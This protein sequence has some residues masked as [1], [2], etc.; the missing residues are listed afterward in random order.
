MADRITRYWP[1]YIGSKKVAE[2]HEQTA[3]VNP[4]KALFYDAEGVG[5]LSIGAAHS[6]IQVMGIDPVGG[7]SIDFIALALGSGFIDVG[8]PQ[9]DGT[10]KTIKMGVTNLQKKT[11]SETGRSD[12]SFTLLGGA[13]KTT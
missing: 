1:L 12:F 3:D 11:N 4:N 7:T 5:G 10:L 9:T 8:W 13:P 6:Q 2:A